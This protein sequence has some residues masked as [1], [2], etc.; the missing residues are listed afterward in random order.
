MVWWAEGKIV[1]LGFV[2]KRD[3]KSE[4]WMVDGGQLAA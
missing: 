1:F 4:Q 3:R 2:C